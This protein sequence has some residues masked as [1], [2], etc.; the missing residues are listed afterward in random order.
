MGSICITL[1]NGVEFYINDNNQM[2]IQQIYNNH[3]IKNIQL[4]PATEKAF[5]T[6]LLHMDSLRIHMIKN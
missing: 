4:G 3:T 5:D 1:G 6:M 2:G